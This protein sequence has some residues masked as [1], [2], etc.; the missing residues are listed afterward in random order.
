MEELFER[1]D[2][3]VVFGLEAQGHIPT[4]EAIIKRWNDSFKEQF[5]DNEYSVNMMYSK[6]VWDEIGKAIGWCPFTAALNYFE[7]MSKNKPESELPIQEITNKE[8]KEAAEGW[9]EFITPVSPVRKDQAISYFIQ[10]VNWYRS[11]L[12]LRIVTELPIQDDKKLTSK[13]CNC[14]KYRWDVKEDGNRYCTN[15]GS[16]KTNN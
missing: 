10:G 5:T 13:N 7:Y 14:M 1:K 15:C 3:K 16:N 8:I 11:N 2:I 6:H 4:I 12:G 9:A